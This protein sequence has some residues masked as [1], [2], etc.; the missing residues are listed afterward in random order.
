MNST[1]L[2]IFENI[3]ENER[4]WI[5][6]PGKS[7]IHIARLVSLVCLAV[8]VYVLTAFVVIVVMYVMNHFYGESGSY[9]ALWS[10]G[11]L[12]IFPMVLPILSNWNNRGFIFSSVVVDFVEALIYSKIDMNSIRVLL[13]I[14]GFFLYISINTF[15]TVIALSNFISEESIIKIIEQRQVSFLSVIA[16]I[17]LAIYLSIRILLIPDKTP[18]QKQIK[19]VREFRL[20]LIVLLVTMFY[21]GYKLFTAFT[22]VDMTYLIGGILVSI[23]R[24]IST[25]KELRK[26]II[27]QKENLALFV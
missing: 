27:E 15:I 19:L 13:E 20:W 9:G 5:D 7:S 22:P 6:R 12:F 21:M 2:S 23:V 25:Y 14:F 10:I 26:V 24:F 4:E 17:H 1:L 8:L 3:E 18:E 16:T 11:L